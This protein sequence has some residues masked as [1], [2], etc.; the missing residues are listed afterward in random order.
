MSYELEVLKLVCQRLEQYK[1]PYMLTGS[2]AANFYTIP[3]M[4]RDIDIVIQIHKAEIDRIV[5]IF[6]NDFYVD[7]DSID[8]AIRHQG[9]FNMI[10]I[11]SV[12]KVDFII[13]KDVSYRDTE[14]KRRQRILLGDTPIWIVAP[15]DLIISK[16]FWSKDSL[17]EMQIKDIKNIILSVKNLD[18]EYIHSW[19]QK[20]ELIQIY[21]KVKK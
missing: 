13:L 3:R 7:R 11:E 16:L 6:K 19:V 18:Q 12:Y 1:L 9:M 8:E 10:H 2:F 17:S 21:E 5:E 20:L 4:T 14:F 15:E